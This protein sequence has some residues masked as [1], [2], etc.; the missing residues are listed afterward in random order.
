M[1][2]FREMH[3][4]GPR[5]TVPEWLVLN[6]DHNSCEKVGKIWPRESGMFSYML[7]LVKLK[8]YRVVHQGSVSNHSVLH[9]VCVQDV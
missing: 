7:S 9:G 2:K 1:I 3:R 6:Q 4:N 5:M 8:F